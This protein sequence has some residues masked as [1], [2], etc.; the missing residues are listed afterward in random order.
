MT[1]M[2]IRSFGLIIALALSGWGCDQGGEDYQR[3]C[4]PGQVWPYAR[5]EAKSQE[6]FETEEWPLRVESP[7]ADLPISLE[8]PQGFKVNFFKDPEG[9]YSMVHLIDRQGES[10]YPTNIMFSVDY[11]GNGADIDRVHE[12]AKEKLAH[13]KQVAEPTT[14]RQ[15]VG[16]DILVWRTAQHTMIYPPYIKNAPK[17]TIREQWTFIQH[18]GKIYEWRMKTMVPVSQES[19]N[20][21][22]ICLHSLVFDID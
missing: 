1:W 9:Q 11:T 14:Y 19:L 20:V 10:S 18:S 5:Q 17:V 6:D 12:V 8:V 15:K 2:S 22:N 3:T 16:E 4:L 7:W 21:L 13:L